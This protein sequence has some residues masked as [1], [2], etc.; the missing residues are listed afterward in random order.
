MVR[1]AGNGLPNQPQWQACLHCCRRV[2]NRSEPSTLDMG[3]TAKPMP[4]HCTAI[5][6]VGSLNSGPTTSNTGSVRVSEQA[7]RAACC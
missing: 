6:E 2:V 1:D 3:D 5:Q 4:A 7:L